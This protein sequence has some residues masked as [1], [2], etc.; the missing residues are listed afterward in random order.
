MSFRKKQARSE[1]HRQR[2]NQGHDPAKELR[3]ESDRSPDGRAL[4]GFCDKA[5]SGGA[6]RGL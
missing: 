2:T 5:V 1:R 4:S 3:P 6:E